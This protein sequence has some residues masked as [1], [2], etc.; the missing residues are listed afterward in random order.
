MFKLTSLFIIVN[1]SLQICDFKRLRKRV[2]R[3]DSSLPPLCCKKE[4]QKKKCEDFVS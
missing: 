3:S 4:K 2:S 1:L